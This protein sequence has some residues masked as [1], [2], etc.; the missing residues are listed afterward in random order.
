MLGKIL[1]AAVMW[2]VVCALLR[3][4]PAPGW[5]VLSAGTGKKGGKSM[6]KGGRT[7]PV[8]QTGEWRG[9]E[10]QWFLCIALFGYCEQYEQQVENRCAPTLCFLLVAVGAGTHGTSMG[11]RL[12]PWDRQSGKFPVVMS[13]FCFW[14]DLSTKPVLLYLSCLVS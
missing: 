14:V 1:K 7:A 8:L 10:S 2:Q 5:R 3:L 11:V 12:A 9:G 4:C 13:R 6:G